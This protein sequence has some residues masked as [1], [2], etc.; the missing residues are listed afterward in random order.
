MSSCH[1]SA[2]TEGEFILV[3]QSTETPAPRF[4]SRTDQ[5]EPHW[6]YEHSRRRLRFLVLTIAIVVVCVALAFA[7]RAALVAKARGDYIAGQQALAAGQFHVAI[8]HLRAA[9]VMGRPYADAHALL[10]DAIALFNGQRE[11]VA[12][13]TGTSQPTTPASRAL[14]QAAAFFA[15]GH[16]SEALARL[17]GL[18]SRLPPAVAAARL[19]A[20]SGTVAAVLLLVSANEA[21]AAHDWRVAGADAAGVLARYPRCAPAAALAA[22]AGRRTRA[23]PFAVRAAALAAAGRWKAAL[24]AVRRALRIDP[25]YPGAV[26]LLAR[27]DAT[28]A[29]RKAA[30]AKVAAAKAAAKAAAAKAAA[31]SA[32]AAT[33]PSVPSYT[34]PPVAPKPTPKPPPPP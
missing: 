29:R 22:E 30:R 27:V 21:F 15:A 23:E 19:P 13:L 18:P 17:A 4:W 6:V 11:Y 20:G 32:A 31:R 3:D 33:T 16:Y 25:T 12:A 24:V 14:R 10:N 1:R 7:G 5:F 2:R 26:A 9:E 8:Q 28:L 34:P